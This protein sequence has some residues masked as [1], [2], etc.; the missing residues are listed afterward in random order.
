M[1]MKHT[2]L[3]TD[4][5]PDAKGEDDRNVYEALWKGAMKQT[6]SIPNK[7]Y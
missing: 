7:R 2:T 5:W 6:Q 4:S 3:Q 1:E